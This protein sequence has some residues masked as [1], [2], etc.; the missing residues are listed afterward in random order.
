MNGII[1]NKKIPQKA[2]GRRYTMETDSVPL[3]SFIL[4]DYMEV[5]AEYSNF[6]FY[7]KESIL[8]MTDF[9]LLPSF[10]LTKESSHLP[11]YN[12]SLSYALLPRFFYTS[13]AS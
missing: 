3:I 7:D 11:H 5:Y 4:N 9:N 12:S 10:M 6:S 1:K 13:K 8:R 2:A